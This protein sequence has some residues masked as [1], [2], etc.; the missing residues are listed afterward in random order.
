M[1]SELILTRKGDPFYAGPLGEALTVALS[2]RRM[3]VTYQRDPERQP[4]FVELSDC[5]AETHITGVGPCPEAA[6]WGAG[7]NLETALRFA[8]GAHFGPLDAEYMGDEALCKLLGVHY[9]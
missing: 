7:P 2:D 3:H 4:F 9:A 5:T 8:L 6:E 1:N